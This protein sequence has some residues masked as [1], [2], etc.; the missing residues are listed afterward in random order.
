MANEQSSRTDFGPRWL[1]A[2]L[3]LAGALVLYC[4]ARAISEQ[5]LIGDAPYHLL[6]GEQALRYGRNQLNLEHPPLVKLLAA[7]PLLREVPFRDNAVSI[8]Q[9]IASSLRLFENPERARRVQIRS[10]SVLLVCFGLPLLVACF[11]LGRHWQGAL[12]GALLA[13]SVGLSFTFLPFLAVIQTDVPVTLGFVLTMTALLRYQ[14]EPGPVPAILVALGLALAIGTKFSGLLLVPSLCF[15]VAARS[16]SLPSSVISGSSWLLAAR[17]VALT[18]GI[19]LALVASTY[20]IAN[21][22]H[23]PAIGRDTL[24]RYLQGEGMITDRQML[25]YAPLIRKVD[26]LA[27]N[28]AQWLTGLLGIRTQNEIGVYPSYAFGELSSQGRWWYFPS[29]LLVKTPLVLIAAFVFAILEFMRASIRDKSCRL[30][31]RSTLLL[32]TVSLYLIVALSSN[33]NLGIRHLLPILPFVF[34]PGA[35]WAAR[36][37]GRA[38]LLILALSLE[39]I[40]LSPLWMSA[41]NTWWLGEHNPSRFALSGSDLEYRQNF[42]ALDRFARDRGIHDMAVVYPFLSERELQAYVSGARL[43]KPRTAL[44]PESWIFVNVAVEQYLSAIVAT[45]PSEVRGY[46]SLASLEREW[47]P[48]LRELAQGEDLGH[49]AGTFHLYRVPSP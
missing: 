46:E 17:D 2:L 1:L 16:V 6:A 12:T 26:Q 8:E 5:S 14:K 43:A 36:R 3:V 29:V 30:S 39:A 40:A 45:E 31:L 13:L 15:Y 49:V 28:A 11:F 22:N 41:T 47:S 7:L 37:K 48:F 23:D 34:L 33:Y 24:E 19:A 32:S 4:Q 21:R 38:A 44:G 35:R 9:A 18:L 25:A 27:P 20:A 10:R 42:I